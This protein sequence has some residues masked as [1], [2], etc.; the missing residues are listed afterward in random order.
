MTLNKDLR[1]RGT[2]QGETWDRGKDGS[3]FPVWLI[4]ST[5]TNTEGLVTHYV[6]SMTDITARK[7]TEDEIRRLAF[8]DPLTGLPNRRLLMD[9]LGQAMASA[10]S[11]RFCL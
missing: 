5:V 4:I 3:I 2:W 11:A 10:S 7:A 9:R 6:V 1:T 8:Y